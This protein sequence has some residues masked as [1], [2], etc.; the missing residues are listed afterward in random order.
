MTH[1]GKLFFIV[2]SVSGIEFAA[3]L[4]LADKCSV[5]FRKHFDLLDYRHINGVSIDIFAIADCPLASLLHL[6]HIGVDWFAI[7]SHALAELRIHSA[8]AFAIQQSGQQGFVTAGFTVCFGFV[9]FQRFLNFNPSLSGNDARVQTDSNDPFTWRQVFGG[10]SFFL[11]R[12]VIG[13]NT[14]NA[15]KSTYVRKQIRINFHKIVISVLVSN[16]IDRIL[17]NRLNGKTSEI[18]VVLCFDA[19]FH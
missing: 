10:L 17:Q 18:S 13:H 12:A 19:S 3:L 8:S 15:V 11:V 14:M 5:I 2:R 16:N 4:Q 9:A 6:A 7:C 1:G